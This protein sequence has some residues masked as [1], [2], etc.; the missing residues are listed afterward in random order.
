MQLARLLSVRS[1]L[2]SGQHRQLHLHARGHLTRPSGAVDS[3]N[4]AINDLFHLRLRRPAH[5]P[6]FTPLLHLQTLSTPLTTLADP[7]RP[8]LF[9][10]LLPAPN[11]ISTDLPVYAVSLLDRPPKDVR[12]PAIMGWLLAAVRDESGGEAGLGDFR[13]NCE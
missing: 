3:H 9:Y 10:H 5:S 13:E 6:Q 11:S 2:R 4:Y 8:S 7:S 1:F 12:S